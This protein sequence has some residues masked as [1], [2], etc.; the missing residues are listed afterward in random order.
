MGM[1]GGGICGCL[2]GG[3]ICGCSAAG[4]GILSGVENGCG[5]AAACLRSGS[6][7]CGITG[8]GGCI[9]DDSLILTSGG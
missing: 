6:G 2:G 8:A 7:G 9:I 5:I 4:K 1:F 3:G